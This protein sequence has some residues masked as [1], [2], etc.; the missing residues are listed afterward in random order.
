MTTLLIITAALE[1][2][3]GL[4]LSLVPD[5]VVSVLLGTAHDEPAATTVSRVAGA[6]L[7][8]V[9]LACWLARHNGRALVI[10]MLLY[11]SATVVVLAHAGLGLG[12]SGIG[13]WPAVGLHT[14]LAVW[15][16][17]CLSKQRVRP[18]HSSTQTG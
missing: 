16:V 13:L 17:A 12:L 14:A 1:A 7:L 9:A 15:C 6:A 2:A 5:V 3:T 4:A 11:N 18:Q 8:A 10:A